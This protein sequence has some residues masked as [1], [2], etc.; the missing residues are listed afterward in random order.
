MNNKSKSN[1]NKI[2]LLSIL[3]ILS[4]I[5]LILLKNNI[6]LLLF[7]LSILFLDNLL[8]YLYQIDINYKICFNIN[9]NLN[10]LSNKFY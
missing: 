3:S 2:S 7:T 6:N 8:Y 9:I 1:N 5:L 10:L 4:T